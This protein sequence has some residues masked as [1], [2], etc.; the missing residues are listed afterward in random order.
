MRQTKLSRS[1]INLLSNLK[2]AIILLL[3]I[4]VASGL[5][6]LIEQNQNLDFYKTA[7]PDE[8]TL[9]NWQ[10]ILFFQLNNI[11]QA[12]WYLSLIGILG[13]SLVTCTFKTQYPIFKVSRKPLF[14]TSITQFTN[15]ISKQVSR[16]TFSYLMKSLSSN[17]YFIFAKKNY[18]YC[19]RGLISKVAPISIHL[20]LICLLLGI[21][22]SALTGYVS[23]EM[24]VTG[25]I[26]HIQNLSTYGKLSHFPQSFSGRVNDFYITY[27]PE[28]N[29]SQ[30]YS[31][32]SIVNNQYIEQQHKQI[33]V[34]HPLKFDDTTIYQ[35]DWNIIGINAL[36]DHQWNVQIPLNK[37]NNN[38]ATL[39]Q[40]ALMSDQQLYLSFILQDLNAPGNI[41]VYNQEGQL[42]NQTQ[43]AD[44]VTLGNHEVQLL[45][46]ITA[47]GLQ[48]KQDPGIKLVYF[49]FFCLIISVLINTASYEEIW[50]LRTN[51]SLYIKG[52]NQKNPVELTKQV[53]QFLKEF[54]WKYLS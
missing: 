29:I 38:G 2:F 11:F 8:Q 49:G 13:L 37:I 35:T 52:K 46:I 43:V 22:L 36:L 7:Y 48:V 24:V 6:T 16:N 40:G 9:F 14:F 10:V 34:N 33:S 28:G 41:L 32:I 26:F 39:W 25:E 47:T 4:A 3:L 42:I 1:I 19:H 51:T 23:Q 18:V 30:F 45:D 31:D 5:G 12:N 27:D 54:H 44:T 17:N 21:T 53:M 20:S 15:L 50:L